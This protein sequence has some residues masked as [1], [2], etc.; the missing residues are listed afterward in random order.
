MT[1]GGDKDPS[2]RVRQTSH[3]DGNTLDEEKATLMLETAR[4]D[5][6]A[7]VFARANARTPLAR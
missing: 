1:K 7:N 3:C 6:G 4:D 5:V 2:G